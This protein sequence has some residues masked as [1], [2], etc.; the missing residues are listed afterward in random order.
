MAKHMGAR[1]FDK[2]G[3]EL[4]LECEKCGWAG[5]AMEALN[6]VYEA[7]ID[8]ECPLCNK[9]ILILNLYK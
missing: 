6:E 8:F 1:E 9:M 2:V 7:V 4:I 3:Q 5:K